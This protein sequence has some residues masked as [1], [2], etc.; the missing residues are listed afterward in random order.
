VKGTAL[1]VDAAIDNNV[2]LA[3]RNVQGIEVT[4]ADNL[5]TYQVLRPNKL[6]VT[7]SAL[8]KLE[9]RLKD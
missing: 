7:K 3:S 5:N 8:E 2:L 1:V 9:A 6:L 4:T